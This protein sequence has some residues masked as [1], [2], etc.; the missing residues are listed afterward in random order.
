MLREPSVTRILPC[1][2]IAEHLEWA[3]RICT[4]SECKLSDDPLS[5]LRK[6][7]K[8]GH[9]SVFEQV[10]LSFLL[11]HKYPLPV[12]SYLA[13]SGAKEG[14]IVSGSVRAFIEADNAVE[15][16]YLVN[17]ALPI[18]EGI[19]TRPPPDVVL[20][21]QDE[22]AELLPERELEKHACASILFDCS[23]AISHELVR[24]RVFS[25]LQ[26]S[27]RF[28]REVSFIKPVA[29]MLICWLALSEYKQ[30]L[31][32]GEKPE[33]ARRVLPNSTAT[34]LLMT[35]TLAQWRG[36]FKLRC[37]KACDPEMQLLAKKARTLIFSREE[38][39]NL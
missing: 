22:L 20:L 2:R 13:I 18:L 3:A 6:L 14:V 32:E 21:R 17:Q 4:G 28:T 30:L 39:T 38:A 1:A 35:G 24:H 9:Y 34:R 16:R 12:S 15:F 10:R 29:S 37:S 31:K 19:G 36:F 7:W 25:F 5:F 26:R 27:Q 11:P 33:F 23:R 8:L